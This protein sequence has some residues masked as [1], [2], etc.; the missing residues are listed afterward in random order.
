MQIKHSNYFLKY[1]VD[2]WYAGMV[3]ELWY[4]SHAFAGQLERAFA[5]SLRTYA[6]CYTFLIAVKTTYPAFYSF[7]YNTYRTMF[8]HNMAIPP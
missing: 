7:Q 6:G 2:K 4:V 3:K 1:G 8:P 5:V